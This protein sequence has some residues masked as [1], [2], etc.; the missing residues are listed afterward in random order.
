MLIVQKILANNGEFHIAGWPP[1]QPDIERNITGNVLVRQVV[2]IPPRAI[3][4]QVIRQIHQRTQRHLMMRTVA[5]DSERAIVHAVS[6]L[7]ELNLQVAVRAAPAPPLG[8]L[9]ISRQLRAISLALELVLEEEWKAHV[10]RIGIVR[11]SGLET[12]QP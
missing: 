9:K 11:R 3:E 6:L 2:H 10:C 1:T 4:L 12:A 5:G 8:G 7:L